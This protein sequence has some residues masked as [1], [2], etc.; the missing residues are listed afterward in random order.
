MAAMLSLFG[1]SAMMA[2]R[3]SER[4]ISYRIAGMPE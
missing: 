2:A 3:Y 1:A 4:L